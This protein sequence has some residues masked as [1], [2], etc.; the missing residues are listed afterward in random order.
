MCPCLFDSIVLNM[1]QLYLF[2][3]EVVE[4]VNENCD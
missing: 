2:S 1:A 4:V 3:R